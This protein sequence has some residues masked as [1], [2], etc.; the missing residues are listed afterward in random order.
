MRFMVLLLVV[1]GIGCLVGPAPRAERSFGGLPVASGPAPLV[2]RVLKGQVTVGPKSVKS[3]N[4]AGVKAI[5]SVDAIVVSGSVLTK[6]LSTGTTHFTLKNTSRTVSSTVR[7][8]AV[9]R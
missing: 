4:P 9:V 1:M 7:W 3:V 5:L 8:V 6:L 2:S